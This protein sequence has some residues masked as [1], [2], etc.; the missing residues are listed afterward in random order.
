MLNMITDWLFT[1]AY[2]VMNICVVCQVILL[3]IALIEAGQKEVEE[4]VEF[5][6][7][8]EGYEDYLAS[9]NERA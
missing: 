9:L 4:L 2:L 5:Y 3:A 8:E 6:E 7:K 1:N